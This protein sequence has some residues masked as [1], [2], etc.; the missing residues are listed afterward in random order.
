MPGQTH[1]TSFFGLN[2]KPLWALGSAAVMLAAAA[3]GPAQAAPTAEVLHWWTS[4][5][6]ARAVK[7][8]KESFEAEG[9]EWIDSPVAGGGG[10][11][12]MTALRSRV[13][14]GDAPTAVQLKAP[15]VKQWAEQG[16]LARLNDVAEDGNWNA[17]I[18]G[19]LQN[20][21]QHEGDYVAV[22]VNIHRI[23]W[24]WANPDALAKVDGEIPKTWA[25]FNALAQKLEAA[26]IT[27]LAHGGQP[28]QDA[29]VFEAVVLGLGGPDFYREALVELD[30]EALGSDTMVQVFEQMRTLR[31]F[32]DANFSGRD[33]NLATSMVI[34]GEA[35]FQIMGDWAKGEITAAGKTPGE[36]VLC[37]AAPGAEGFILNTD[38]FAM[39]EQSDADK[40]AG[41]KLL[42]RLILADDFQTGFNRVKGSIP[43]STTV[44][45]DGFDACARK[46]KDHLNT[47]RADDGLVLSMA[48]GMAISGQVKGAIV[49]VVTNHFNSDMDAETATQRLV[50]AVE[51]ANY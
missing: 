48:H 37:A 19:V 29:T 18:P 9:G 12:A 43:A 32:V 50:E 20:A 7:T 21:M 23:D 28:W 44:A 25:E 30:S 33:W 10:D 8:L 34:A 1:R 13:L 42:A 38:S 36:D 11:A 24:L 35:A 14:S 3:P 40:R 17:K 45:L 15:A 27:P 26:G 41:Q 46:S 5:G 22:P 2:F 31:G 51:L 47:A 39:F 49:D 4:G 6:E 16:Q